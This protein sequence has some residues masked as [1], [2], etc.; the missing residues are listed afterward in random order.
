MHRAQKNVGKRTMIDQKPVE[1]AKL[2]M[3]FGKLGIATLIQWS[4]SRAPVRPLKE[5]FS[6]RS[7]TNRR[8]SASL[9]NSNNS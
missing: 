4:A 6:K 9:G 2:R 3:A 8:T 1:L 5:T 7:T